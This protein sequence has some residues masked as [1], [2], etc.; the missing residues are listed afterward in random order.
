M[1]LLHLK[2]CFNTF[3]L[4]ILRLK[5]VLFHTLLANKQ[6]TDL[7]KSFCVVHVASFSFSFCSFVCPRSFFA[8]SKFLWL[9]IRLLKIFFLFFVSETSSKSFPPPPPPRVRFPRGKTGQVVSAGS[10]KSASLEFESLW[11]KR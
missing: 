11:R 1:L 6:F 8:S 7:K 10:S 3:A 5:D 4:F 9:L 2:I